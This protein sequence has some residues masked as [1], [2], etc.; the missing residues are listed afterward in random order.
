VHVPDGVADEHRV[1]GV[2]AATEQVIGAPLSEVS[3]AA[4]SLF[5]HLCAALAAGTPWRDRIHYRDVDQHWEINVV[6]AE[7][8]RVAVSFHDVTDQARLQ[9]DT[10]ASARNASPTTPQSH[11]IKVGAS[12]GFDDGRRGRPGPWA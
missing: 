3:P 11:F 10:E 9:A 8:D 1:G 4:S 5:P 12:Q 2:E 6:R 7:A